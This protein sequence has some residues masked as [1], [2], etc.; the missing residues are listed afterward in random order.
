MTYEDLFTTATGGEHRPYPYQSRLAR[1]NWPDLLSVPTGLGKTAAVVL[2][3][4]HRRMANDPDTPRR[5]VYGLPMRTLAE[6]TAENCR[7]WLTRL[8]MLAAPGEGGIS[9]SLLMGGEDDVRSATWARFPE[10][11]AILVG[12]QDMLISRA[13]MRGYGMSRYQWPMH[14]GLL[15]S[16]SLWVFDEV[17]LMG[18]ALATSTQ[19]EAFRRRYATAFPSRSL[20]LSATIRSEWLESIDFRPHVPTLAAL[21]LDDDDRARASH[22]LKARKTLERS[23]MAVEKSTPPREL[24]ASVLSRHRAGTQTVVIVNQVGRAQAIFSELARRSDAPDLLLLH[25]RFRPAER[26]RIESELRRELGPAGRIVVATQAVEAGIDI[27]STTLVT[28]LAPWPSMIQRFGRCNRYGEASDEAAVVWLDIR[29]EDDPNLAAPYTPA[30]LQASRAILTGLESAGIDDLPQVATEFKAGAVLRAKDFLQLFDTDPDLSGYD[31]DIA[32]YIRDHGTP[33]AQVFWRDFSGQPDEEM[34]APEPGELCP[35]SITQLND[36]LGRKSANRAVWSWDPL[37]QKWSEREKSAILPGIN[38]LL[39]AADGGYDPMIGFQAGAQGVVPTLARENGTP[40]E[41][42]GDDSQLEGG[43]AVILLDH[44]REVRTQAE[45][46]ARVLAPT[47][48][49]AD[50]IRTAALWHDVGKL[51]PAFQNALMEGAGATSVEPLAKSGGRGRLRYHVRGDDERRIPRPL[52]R[53][54]LVS[55][56]A[57]LS[58]AEPHPDRDLIAYLILAHHGKVRMGLRALPGE[59]PAPGGRR[60]ARGVWEGDTLPPFDLDGLQLPEI[61][62]ALRIMELGRSPA[63]PSWTERTQRL[64]A[65]QGPFVL[66]WM[67]TLLRIA[68]WRGSATR[69]VGSDDPSPE[70]PPVPEIE[71]S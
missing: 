64:L 28:E 44:L 50:A 52:F 27:S 25:A 1:G 30:D 67:E 26:R 7:T 35:V 49:I 8:G 39:R 19:L 31:L 36:Y 22:L 15:H 16:D 47:S 21:S 37:L 9:V 40:N 60:H 2:A 24:A 3:W 69:T 32:P 34:D 62:L 10:E 43:S 61:S 71:M 46:L 18:P 33:R 63:G 48:A 13:L 17:Q 4:I 6:Q 29:I 54:E 51:H 57:W 68:D 59:N 38:Y 53:H 56:L 14:F 66:S 42:L 45:A 23:D 5:L 58:L 41:T 11:N 55:M 20:W 70:S 65:D 12:T